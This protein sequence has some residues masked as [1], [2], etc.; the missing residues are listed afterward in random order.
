MSFKEINE[1]R[2]KGELEEALQ[3][4]NGIWKTNLTVSG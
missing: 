3:M 2:K 1:L 4:V